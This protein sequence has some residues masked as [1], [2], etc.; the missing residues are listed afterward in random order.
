MRRWLFTTVFSG[1]CAFG[2]TLAFALATDSFLLFG[3]RRLSDGHTP[4]NMRL[5]TSGD[6][7]L[8]AVEIAQAKAPLDVVFLGSSRTAFG[9]DPN[10]PTLSRVKAY[11]AGLNGSHAGE[12]AAVLRYIVDRGPPVRRFVWNIDFEEFFRDDQPNGDF[13]DSALAGKPVLRTLGR[14]ALSYNALRKSFGGLFGAQ[15]F[16]VDSDGFYHYERRERSAVRNGDDFVE[17]PT[18]DEW[19]PGYMVM[20]NDTFETSIA[21]RLDMIARAIGY[22][23]NH[24]AAVDIVMMP[25]H[26]TRRAM[27]DA[28]GF[29]EQ[30]ELW[31]QRLSQALSDLV[32]R[33]PVRVFDFCEI[34]EESLTPFKRGGPLERS[35]YFFEVLHPRPIIGDM[36][37]ARL[38]DLSPPVTMS[39]EF[40]APLAETS[41][42]ERLAA[43][44]AALRAWEQDHPELMKQIVA[45]VQ[46]HD[47]RPPRR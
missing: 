32:A 24:G 26:V 27:F 16:Y 35:P 41:K 46:A 38:L 14:H 12:M 45:T 17:M 1:L 8:K 4:W 13:A 43:D 40:G 25:A 7:E 11:N 18:L 31:K 20:A 22:A 3:T 21:A 29:E 15:P 36:I 10:S 28:A 2:A 39:H 19:F 33:G 42:A 30:F 6:R 47:K 5:V 44:R 34:D 9:F 37:A 23:V